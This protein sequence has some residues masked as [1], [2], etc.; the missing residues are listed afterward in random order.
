MKS[1]KVVAIAVIPII[2]VSLGLGIYL[3]SIPSNS[4]PSYSVSSTQIEIN[5][6]SVS[7]SVVESPSSTEQNSTSATTSQGPLSLLRSQVTK[8]T[9]N[10]TWEYSVSAYLGQSNVVLNSTLTYLSPQTNEFEI[11]G[12][13][14]EVLVINEN[15]TVMWSLPISELIRLVNVTQGQFFIDSNQI[16]DSIMQAPGNYTIEL[17]PLFDSSNGTPLGQQLEVNISVVRSEE[18]TLYSNTT[19][20]TVE[21]STVSISQSPVLA[22]NL[23]YLYSDIPAFFNVG[24]FSIQCYKTTEYSSVNNTTQFV[25]D[26]NVTTPNGNSAVFPF[27]WV[28]PCSLNLGTPCEPDN[29]LVLPDPVNASMDYF[30]ATLHIQWY[31]NTT[32]LYAAFQE[33]DQIQKTVSTPS[34]SATV[35]VTTSHSSPTSSS[36]ASLIVLDPSDGAAACDGLGQAGSENWSANVCTLDGSKTSATDIV[37]PG[38]TL[39]IFPDVTLILDEEGLG[40]AN[41]GTIINNGTIDYYNSFVQYGVLDNYG[42]VFTNATF[43]SQIDSYF[44]PDGGTINNYGA[45]SIIGYYANPPYNS[46]APNA[47]SYLNGGSFDNDAI[48]NNY[49]TLNNSGIIQNFETGSS[50]NSTINNFGTLINQ[51]GSEFQNPEFVDNNGN[52]TNAGAFVNSGTL[53]NLCGGNFVEAEDGTYSG[54]PIVRICSTSSMQITTTTEEDSSSS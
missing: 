16:S 4:G 14:N 12:T 43:V 24:N 44:M 53:V 42:E 22:E 49:G 1:S 51:P 23:A 6:T 37:R 35:T 19:L 7:R 8:T 3:S 52:I 18:T 33:W 28:P 46:S 32:G 10:N 17:L 15:G 5:S 39:Q 47:T 48:F 29:I 20:T 25:F 30:E 13:I 50:F 40:F 41:Y 21:N 38:L 54:N 27:L 31:S 34:G 45:I 26:F 36:N 9:F 2:A 11:Q